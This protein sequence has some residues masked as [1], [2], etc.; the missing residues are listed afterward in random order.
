M[1]MGEHSEQGSDT[2]EEREVFAGGTYDGGGKTIYSRP[3]TVL[4][5]NGMGYGRIPQGPRNKAGSKSFYD[6]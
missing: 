5:L 2:A 6:W 3:G 4:T 1:Y